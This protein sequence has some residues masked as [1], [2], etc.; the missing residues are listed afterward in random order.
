MNTPA[1]L[2]V[3]AFHL[4][5]AVFWDAIGDSLSIIGMYHYIDLNP[6][7]GTNDRMMI[8]VMFSPKLELKCYLNIRVIRADGTP[9]YNDANEFDPDLLGPA[10]WLNFEFPS[11]PPEAWVPDTDYTFELW[12]MDRRIGSTSYHCPPVE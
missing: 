5:R 8:A 3:V 2:K 12:T 1:D 7:T 11:L 9:V 10:L 4:A 6:D